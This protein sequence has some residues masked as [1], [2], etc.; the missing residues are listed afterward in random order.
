MLKTFLHESCLLQEQE[1]TIRF[2]SQEETHLLQDLIW[3]PH[4]YTS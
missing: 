2:Q 1:R 3:W 4:E